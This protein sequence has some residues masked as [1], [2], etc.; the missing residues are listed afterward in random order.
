MWRPL[1][2]SRQGAYRFYRFLFE[3]LTALG[4]T[5]SNT[6]EAL[7]YKFN[8]DGTYLILGAA[9]DNFT[10]VVDSDPTADQFLDEFEKRV[11]LVCLG[12]ITWLLGRWS[13][14]ILLIIQSCLAKRLISTKFA[15]NLDCK[16]D[17]QYRH[18]YHLELTSHLDWNMSCRK[19]YQHLKRKP[20][21]KLL[22]Y[23]CTFQ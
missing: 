16:M 14:E 10:I 19:S 23:S 22:G 6:D 13:Q 17:D 20:T 18:H 21:E 7:F 4:Y 2:G 11:E 1:Y 9:T 12:Q 5:V 8:S 15:L 3:T